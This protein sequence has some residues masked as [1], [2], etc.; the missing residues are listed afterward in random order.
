MLLKKEL[1]NP[2]CDKARTLFYLAQSYRD[3]QNNE[4]AIKYYKKRAVLP[5]SW[6]EERYISYL[7]LIRLSDSIEEKIKYAWTAQN[8]IPNRKEC[9]GEV[10]HYARLRDIFTQELYAMG[11][12]FKDTPLPDKGL[13]LEPHLYGWSYDEDIG[14]EA[15][16]TG[17]FHQAAESF[18]SSLKTC[19]DWAKNIMAQNLRH[20]LTHI[21]AAHKA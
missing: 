3:S 13:F 12:A 1:E 6:I 7:C 2:D 15:Y 8:L 21:V 14:L 4:Q 10:L 18:K 19:P 9:V 20:A 16:Y 11:L 5:N 17:H